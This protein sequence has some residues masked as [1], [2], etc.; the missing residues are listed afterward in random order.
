M[1]I[2]D[3]IERL[4]KDIRAIENAAWREKREL[5]SEETA[6]REYAKGLLASLD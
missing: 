4:E 2:P 3:L 5:S 6:L 1:T